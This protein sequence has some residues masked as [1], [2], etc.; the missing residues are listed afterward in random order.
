MPK[1]S[2]FDCLAVSHGLRHYAVTA[3]KVDRLCGSSTSRNE[4][5]NSIKKVCET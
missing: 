3:A 1:P 2:D 4:L 5:I